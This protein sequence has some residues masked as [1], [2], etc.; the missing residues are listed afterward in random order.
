MK[1]TA[2]PARVSMAAA[3]RAAAEAAPLLV[4]TGRALADLADELGSMEAAVGFLLELAEAN[5]RPIATN[6]PTGDE[7]SSTAFV[8]PAGWTTARLRGWVAR[9][10]RELEAE[11][12]EISRAGCRFPAPGGGER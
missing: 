8:A 1:I 4:I 9:H 6:V 10:H 7:T 5:D 11:F 2:D 12:G 3:I